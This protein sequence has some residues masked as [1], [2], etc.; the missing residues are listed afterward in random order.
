MIDLHASQVLLTWMEAGII[1]P[2]DRAFAL[3]IDALI[4]STTRK[5][6]RSSAMLAAL[7]VSAVHGEGHTALSLDPEDPVWRYSD[8]LT[9][10]AKQVGDWP[11]NWM[12]DL[13]ELPEC[14]CS[15]A[16]K[17]GALVAPLLR[18]GNRLYLHRCWEDEQ[19]VL[20]GLLNRADVA[21][22]LTPEQS[23]KAEDLL[24][25]LFKEQAGD[26]KKACQQA[27]QHALTLVT[28]GPGTGKTY[29]VIRLLALLWS[30]FPDLRVA[31]AAPTGKAAA[32]IQESIDHAWEEVLGHFD[33][34]SRSRLQASRQRQPKAQT[35]H[36]LLARYR[37][38]PGTTLPFD[39]VLVDEA[40]MVDL[41]MMAQLVRVL[42]AK[43][44]LVLL[45]DR[46]QLAS[47]E[48]GMVLA[49]L[50]DYPWNHSGTVVTLVQSHR[51]KGRIRELADLILKPDL[52]EEDLAAIH[53][54]LGGGLSRVPENPEQGSDGAVACWSRDVWGERIKE[55]WR[56]YVTL[57][58]QGSGTMDH[59]D[60]VGRVIRTFDQVRVLTALRK[61]PWGAEQLNPWIG[62]HLWGEQ[63][64]Q[65]R[66]YAGLP[67][68][69]T[70]NDYEQQL[71][72]GDIGMILPD[73]EGVLRAFFL[74]GNELQSVGLL[75]L[76]QVETAYALTVH[77]SQGSEYAHTLLVLPD[78]D[79]PVL[80][81]E[82]IYTGLTRAKQRFTLVLDPGQWAV[83]DQALQRKT[84]R[85]S[86]LLDTEIH[87]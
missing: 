45:G 20:R 18:K 75:R 36:R 46:N 60:W 62:C 37:F 72:N 85:S 15:E 78:R 23:T 68:M 21:L 80:S 5:E 25:R 38:E 41:S 7:C 22:Y 10:L 28:G 48:P 31:M 58:R 6:L 64:A 56:A 1:R 29:T 16:I 34:A 86:G 3:W 17:G 42:S 55:E 47:V 83:L 84:R 82:L 13:A 57:V 40:S 24:G 43:T 53:Q 70:V 73:H 9:T 79:S 54:L 65:K 69:V 33:N 51:F 61:G 71:F 8:A 49:D 81:W 66:Y 67:V 52:N 19:T 87:A 50:C 76:P 30:L 59:Q 26:Q 77:K 27:V 35:L 14:I 63:S 39:L 12:Q 4:P 32:R 74:R 2:L 11:E 44:R